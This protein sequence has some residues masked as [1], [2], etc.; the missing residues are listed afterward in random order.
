M[1]LDGND[2]DQDMNGTSQV[3]R[4]TEFDEDEKSSDDINE[5]LFELYGRLQLPPKKDPFVKRI[6]IMEELA[7]LKLVK[8]VEK[9]GTKLNDKCDFKV[10]SMTKSALYKESPLDKRKTF[11]SL[12]K[13]AA[14]Q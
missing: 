4:E 3:G 2:S 7:L 14:S 6:Q 5:R 1:S 13:K 12:S 8:E 11:T 10:F 9:T